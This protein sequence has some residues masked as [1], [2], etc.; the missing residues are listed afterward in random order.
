MGGGVAHGPKPRDYRM[1][2]N[3]KMKRGALRSALTD[4]LASG[5]LAVVNGLEFD[6]PRT[7]DAVGLLRALDLA[8]RVL[9]VIARPDEVTEKSFRNVPDVKIGYP[10]NLST[11]DL[12]SADRVLFTSDALDALTGTEEAG[13]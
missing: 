11:F 9:V 6:E 2:V 8:G 1:R 13:R 10:G 3:K 4:T 12:I 5:K 7:K